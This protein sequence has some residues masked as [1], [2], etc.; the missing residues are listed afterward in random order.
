MLISPLAQTPQDKTSSLDPHLFQLA[1]PASAP[2]PSDGDLSDCPLSY[3]L[4][5]KEA[6]LLSSRCPFLTPQHLASGNL[7]AEKKE[8]EGRG[9]RGK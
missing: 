7:W 1:S 2:H 8:D 9:V 6:F 5:R 4:S 3:H